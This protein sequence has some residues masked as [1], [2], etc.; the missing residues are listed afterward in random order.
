MSEYFLESA[1]SDS[2]IYSMFNKSNE[3][4]TKVVKALMNGVRLDRSYIE[5]QIL[6]LERSRVS[7]LIPTV[8]E[9][10][11]K[12]Q[13]ELIYAPSIRL[14]KAIPFIIHRTSDNQI[15]ASIFVSPFASLDK[16]ETRLD[17]PA[18]SLYTLMESAFVS[19]IM[20][21]YPMR[22]QRNSTITKTLNAVYVEMWMRIL[23]R[24]FALTLDKVLHDK[25]AFLISRFFLSVVMEFK[26]NQI[27]ESYAASVA[28]NLS[29]EDIL[30]MMEAYDMGNVKDLESLINVLKTQ[31]TRMNGMTTRYF[32]ERFLN[33]Y[34]QS[35]ILAVDY[36]PY[37]FMIM[38]NTLLGTFIV[39]QPSISDIVKNTPGASKFYPELVKM[40]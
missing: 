29:Q 27:V 14:S 37:M 9:T 17:F 23:N 10:Y 6:I 28:P 11:F 12:G 26:N 1:M 24:E 22:L 7:P 25:V 20:H 32:V 21:V 16:T 5:E 39:N 2:F 13:I 19:I 30:T 33:S 3:M 40:I 4:Q 15:K 34:G 36:A 38:I 35:S 18:K 8:L 31:A